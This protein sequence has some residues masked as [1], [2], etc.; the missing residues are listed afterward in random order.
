MLI[1]ILA[2]ISLRPNLM[3]F[4]R[5]SDFYWGYQE[6]LVRSSYLCLFGVSYCYLSGWD[7]YPEIPSY[8][9][10]VT[11]NC[12]LCIIWSISGRRVFWRE[13][14]G[15]WH[16]LS[17]FL[18]PLQS[19]GRRPLKIIVRSFMWECLGLFD[20]NIALKIF[21][22]WKSLLGPQNIPGL[23]FLSYWILCPRDRHYLFLFQFKN[24]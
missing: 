17:S 7:V 22:L 9:S 11:Y 24:N 10:K 4:L 1:G 13:G 15:K 16:I 21:H 2:Q 5:I 19:L 8:C 3:V 12:W 20:C 14:Q 6:T 23:H 18:F